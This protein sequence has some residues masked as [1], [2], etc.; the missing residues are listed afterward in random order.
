MIPKFKTNRIVSTT[1]ALT[2]SP[3]NPTTPALPPVSSPVYLPNVLTTVSTVS[4]P[5]PST[6][7]KAICPI[8]LTFLVTCQVIVESDIGQKI[9]AR[10]LLDTGAS[11]SLVSQ[12]LVNQLRLHI[13]N[14]PNTIQGVQETDTEHSQFITIQNN[15]LL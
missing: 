9:K 10:A 3:V 7:N 8:S 13:V 4:I 2:S 6:I 12:R 14:Q 1:A 11:T 5:F 15:H